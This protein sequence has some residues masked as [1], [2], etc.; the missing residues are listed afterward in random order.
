MSVQYPEALITCNA[1]NSGIL[2][3]D[4]TAQTAITA[5]VKLTTN[6]ALRKARLNTV[7]GVGNIDFTVPVSGLYLVDAT[8]VIAAAGGAANIS[9]GF[10]TGTT[11]ISYV[12]GVKQ[13]AV[14]LSLQYNALLELDDNVVYSFIAS[15]SASTDIASG[16]I[17][18]LQ[19][20]VT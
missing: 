17:R 4:K 20:P 5:N 14:E 9:L 10:G 1:G 7:A 13:V 18:L 19:F 15:A 3:A 12:S 8:V 16:R 11:F 2:I 6:T